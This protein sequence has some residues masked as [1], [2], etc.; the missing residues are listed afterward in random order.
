MQFCAQHRKDNDRLE[1]VH[2]IGPQ[3]SCCLEHMM[4][5]KGVRAGF[6]HSEGKV[7]GGPSAAAYWESGEEAEPDSSQM[8]QDQ[9]KR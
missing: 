9:S 1:W 6:F 3:G 7:L 2:G 8:P 4:K 5:E